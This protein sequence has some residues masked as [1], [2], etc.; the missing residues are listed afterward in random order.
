MP[1]M[2]ATILMSA[3]EV[4]KS[5]V[6]LI[7]FSCVLFLK[8]NLFCPTKH[9]CIAASCAPGRACSLLMSHNGLFIIYDL[10]TDKRGRGASPLL[11]QLNLTSPKYQIMFVIYQMPPLPTPVSFCHSLNSTSTQVES[12]KVISW[13]TT[14]YSTH[15]S[16][17]KLLRHF[18]TT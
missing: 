6:E 18:Q 5:I 4:T 13:T 17:L 8:E 3:Q 10:M 9:K 11:L 1:A 2:P 15:H 12:D 14:T 16:T 7:F